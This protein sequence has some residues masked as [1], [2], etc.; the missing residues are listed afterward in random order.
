[1]KPM[2]L[3]VTLIVAGVSACGLLVLRRACAV[4]AHKPAMRL[5]RPALN[6]G[7]HSLR[8]HART[9]GAVDRLATACLLA[10]LRREEARQRPWEGRN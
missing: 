7:A 3:C 10:P 8:S 2:T 5:Q 9:S 6:R 1:M 4:V